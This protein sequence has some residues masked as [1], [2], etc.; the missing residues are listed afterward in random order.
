MRYDAGRQSA[1]GGRDYFC[2]RAVFRDTRRAVPRECCRQYN[3][4]HSPLLAPAA[5]PRPAVLRPPSQQHNAIRGSLAVLHHCTVYNTVVL[6]VN[7]V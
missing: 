2:R 1:G 7:T 3:T 5:P 4:A 6:P